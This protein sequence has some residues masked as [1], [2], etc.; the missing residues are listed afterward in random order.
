MKFIIIGSGGC[1]SIPRALCQCKVCTEARQKGAPYS[2]YG[3]SIYLEDVSLLV[4]TPEDINVALNN[5]EITY[6]DNILYSHWDPDHTLGM[7]IIEQLRLEWLDYYENKKPTNPINILASNEVMKDINNI[8]NPYGSFMDYYEHMGLIKRQIVESGICLK[9]K[10]KITFI[11]I[12]KEKAVN[13]FMFE[14]DNKMVIYAPCDCKPFPKNNEINNA[15]ILI[16]GNTFIGDVLKNDTFIYE[17]HPL[18]S[19]LHSIE[20]IIGLKN[21]YK[22]KTAIITHIE[23]DWGKSFDEYKELEKKYK[24]VL[25][26][27]DGM[28]IEL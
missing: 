24:N 27:Y 23:E 10:I 19:E 21:Y 7:R 15:D 8:R 25:F 5:A 20:N 18:R 13:I 12:S 3:C 26:A 4:D 9:N 6:L 1:V 14:Q 28:K 11:P 22:I 16:I 2:R 17:A